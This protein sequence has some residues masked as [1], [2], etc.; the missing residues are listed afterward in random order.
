MK[1]NA[2]LA[3]LYIKIYN[4]CPLTMD[5]LRFLA[6]YDR[7]CFEKTCQNVIYNIPEAKKLMEKRSEQ[8]SGSIRKA[9][10]NIPSA[11]PDV[12]K[13]QMAVGSA[14]ISQKEKI[15]VLLENL[16][17]M[18][19]EDDF[20]QDVTVESVKH[21]LGSLYMEMLFPHNDRHRYFQLEDHVDHSTFN[22]KA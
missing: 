12:P 13:E 8:K 11:G 10:Q 6:V 18:E 19:W 17:K 14:Q 1:K 4:K 7:E 15:G 20:V 3:D 22:K 16:K 21:L 5:D 2:R 9:E